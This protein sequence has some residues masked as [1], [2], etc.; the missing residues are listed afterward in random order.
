MQSKLQGKINELPLSPGVYLY[1]N[2][3]GEI[4]YVGK[5]ARLRNRVK[6][7]F[8]K[9]R[10][11]DPKTDVLVSEIADL[12]TI[13][14]ES[15]ADALFLEAELIKRY[16]PRYNIE[17]RDDKS[18]LFI[19]IDI[20]S[21]QPT[22]SLIRRPLDDRANHFG[23][24]QASLEVKKALRYLRRIFPYD[25]KPAKGSKVNLNFHLGLSPGLEENKQS[26]ETYRSNLR[27]LELILTGQR[28][29]VIKQLESE[30]KQAAK[31]GNYEQ[32]A[33]LRD[34]VRALKHLRQQVVFGDREFMD[35]SK[36]TALVGLQDLLGLDAIPRRI[37]GYDISHLQ[38]TD[39]VASMVVFTSGIPDK[40]QYRKFKL[41]TPGNDD[42]KHMHETIFRRF[43][44]Q[45][46]S[47][48][49]P[50]LLLIDGGKGQLGS[51][52]KALEE[53]G[54][55]IPAIGLAKRR[56]QIVIKN[57]DDFS[58]IE[59]GLNSDIVKLLQRIRD[60]S[61]RFAV[62]YQSSLRGKRQI[63]SVLDEIPGVG[64]ATRK[65]LIKAFGGARAVT[66]AKPEEIAAVVGPKMTETIV[67]H[68]GLK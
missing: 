35:M 50:D 60:E 52:L 47:W 6:Q 30:M 7:Y 29:A 61:H 31:L 16:M 13:E 14:T 53:T 9:S 34:Q 51:A 68:L 67:K 24:Y 22:V 10:V 20:K 49:K 55:D 11:R 63:A 8:Q 54:L 62:T 37:E 39:N 48:P 64:P 58:L 3:A 56:E 38:G 42:F 57:G 23:P 21:D 27:K 32:A 36:D 15:E 4:I 65:K 2:A 1:K 40:S 28:T 25:E 46:K 44:G 18:S 66:M 43:N 17:L 45:G 19:R 33:K 12:D 41:R 59:L 5:A 26:L